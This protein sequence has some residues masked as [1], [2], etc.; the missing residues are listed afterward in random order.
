M[1]YYRLMDAY[2]KNKRQH[3]VLK[4]YHKTLLNET[5]DEEDFDNETLLKKLDDCI[6]QL[7]KRCKAVFYEKKVT[8]L[9]NKQIADTFKISIK[10]VEAHVTKAYVYLKN[11]LGGA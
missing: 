4:E 3:L 2:R 1:V 10:T 8:G 9:K 6:E 7:P 5:L 11:C